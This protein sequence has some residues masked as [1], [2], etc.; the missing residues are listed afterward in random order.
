MSLSLRFGILGARPARV[1]RLGQSA[2]NT[3]LAAGCHLTIWLEGDDEQPLPWGLD[4]SGPLADVPPSTLIVNRRAATA[5]ETLAAARPDFLLQLDDA[6]PATQLLDIPRF[7]VWRF[8][9]ALAPLAFWEVY[10]GLYDSEIRLERLTAN[11]A[12]RIPLDRRW[13]KIERHSYRQTLDSFIG[14]M[15]EMLA[16]VCRCGLARNPEPIAFP[17]Q[18]L[19]P[20]TALQQFCFQVK[21]GARNFLRQLAGMFFSETWRVG[22]VE[23]P[24]ESFA[25]LDYL[26]SP[27]WLPN[28]GAGIVF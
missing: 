8:A 10:D 11:P 4:N 27:R 15:A 13:I 2:I 22:V 1:S 17:P 25:D 23:S 19:V 21:L 3:L 14:E 12:L 9:T 7:G 18:R 16:Y 24:I 6:P 20:P 28:P 5:V 26:P